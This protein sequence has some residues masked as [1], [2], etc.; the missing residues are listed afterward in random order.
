M[1]SP[2]FEIGGMAFPITRRTSFA[3]EVMPMKS[4]GTLIRHHGKA[5]VDILRDPRLAKGGKKIRIDVQRVLGRGKKVVIAQDVVRIGDQIFKLV[6]RGKNQRGS[7]TTPAEGK[8]TA[9]KRPRKK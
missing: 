7:P 2:K 8:A 3:F 6:R 5:T 1:G 9:E 4:G